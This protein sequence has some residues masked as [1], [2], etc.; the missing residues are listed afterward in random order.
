MT[1]LK[2]YSGTASIPR[3]GEALGETQPCFFGGKGKNESWERDTAA[4][5]GWGHA[6]TIRGRGERPFHTLHGNEHR[7]RKMMETMC[8]G[9]ASLLST[10]IQHRTVGLRVQSLLEQMGLK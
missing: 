9:S 2:G 10:D 6:A 3:A 8:C 1:A 5:I 4:E 7:K